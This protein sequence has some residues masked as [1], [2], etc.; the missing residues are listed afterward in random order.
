[1]LALT[2]LVPVAACP[3]LVV[4]IA[5][6]PLAAAGAACCAPVARLFGSAAADAVVDLGPLCGVVYLVQHHNNYVV[7]VVVVVVGKVW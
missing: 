1:M 6:A 2:F 3:T 5:A 4:G 7:V